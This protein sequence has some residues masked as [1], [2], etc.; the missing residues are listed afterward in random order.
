LNG[1]GGNVKA[2]VRAPGG[3]FSAPVTI[4]PGNNTTPAVAMGSG[5]KAVALFSHYDPAAGNRYMQSST[6][7]SGAS[8]WTAPATVSTGPV[9]SGVPTSAT[10][11]PDGTV[12]A[13][14]REEA[15]AIVASEA[16]AAST[17]DT[18]FAVSGPFD[19][20]AQVSDTAIASGTDGTTAVTW[21]VPQ[22]VR[23]ATLAPGSSSWTSSPTLS[24]AGRTD[25]AVGV[26]PSG[27]ATVAWDVPPAQ[28]N[29]FDYQ[30]IE[31]TTN[32]GAPPAPPNT[33]ITSGPA[34]SSRVRDNTP[35]FHF[36]SSLPRSTFACRIDG[37]AFGPCSGPGASHTTRSL[38]DGAHTFQVRATAG[39]AT[40]PSPASRV[41]TVDATPPQTKIT[42]GPPRVT[43]SHTA[44][45]RFTSSERSST[46][47]CRLDRQRFAPCSSP[48][49]YKGLKV[50]K[51]TFSVV[52]TD[53]TGN[54]DR[55]A[56]TRTWKISR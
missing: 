33:T 51:H 14:W 38:R 49:S 3:S 54:P 4:S 1:A 17:F 27:V 19:A 21:T 42:K 31:A 50:G 15:Q 6:L 29:Y 40:D 12:R 11:L 53:R 36:A 55:T 34:N 20:S 2:S 22:G 9:E 10:A 23:A 8:A 24:S 25:P 18:P 26:D 13:I 5:G 46:F 28:D 7:A 44:S 39:G 32:G 47:R 45:F 30:G 37:G 48:R 56:A 35:T 52:A 41:F 16:P 43:R